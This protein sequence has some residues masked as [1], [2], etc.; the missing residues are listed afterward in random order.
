MP[1]AGGKVVAVTGPDGVGKSTIIR[2]LENIGRGKG[3]IFLHFGLPNLLLLDQL[4][5]KIV[6][7]RNGGKESFGEISSKSYSM[8]AK[9]YRLDLAIRRAFITN[10]GRWMTKFGYIVVFDRYY[11]E[12]IAVS[13]DGRSLT[14]C[15]RLWRKFEDFFY[16]IIPKCDQ[17][18][19]IVP[20]LDVAIKRNSKR[21][22]LNKESEKT[23]IRR[24]R[25]FEMLQTKT[26]NSRSIDNSTQTIAETTNDVLNLIWE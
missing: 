20:I 25:E 10:F 5:N 1:L 17:E 18:I 21:D 19:K 22:K 13:V 23:I 15:G 8:V 7:T 2:E 4:K 12:N 16:R 11:N 26:K 3:M 24:F 9:F 14:D 6:A